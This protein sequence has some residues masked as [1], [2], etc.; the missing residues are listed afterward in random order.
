M[1]GGTSENFSGGALF[2]T[3][4]G[5]IAAGITALI[6]RRDPYKARTSAKAGMVFVVI[7]TLLI[8]GGTYQ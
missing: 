2:L 5:I 8:W 3:I 6:K 7:I 1:W 4:V